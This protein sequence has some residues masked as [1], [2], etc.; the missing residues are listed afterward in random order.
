M[1]GLKNL[2]HEEYRAK[3]KEYIL[4]QQIGMGLLAVLMLLFSFFY[5]K[6][7]KASYVYY[8]EN[9]NAIHYAHL[10]PKGQEIFGTDKLNGTHA[11]VSSLVEKMSAK[12]TYEINFVTEK[13]KYKYNYD[14]QTQ[15]EVTDV[16]SRSPLY[17][18]IVATQVEKKSVE[19]EGSF[20]KIAEDVDINFKAFNK[21]A[22]DFVIQNGLVETTSTLIVRMSVT[23]WGASEN[24]IT[25]HTDEYVT[26]LRVPLRNLAFKP[27]VT[28]SV[29]AGEKKI[30]AVS[31]NKG[32]PFLVLAIVSASVLVWLG[33]WFLYFVLSTKDEFVDYSIK[34][35]RIYKN[36]QSYIQ[37]IEE[38]F[39]KA[40]RK[41]L[42]L[43][44]FNELLEIH[45]L[46]Q[47]P[48]L[49]YEN[50]EKT[51]TE[52]VLLSDSVL[53]MHEIKVQEPD[54][55]TDGETAQFAVDEKPVETTDE[56][57]KKTLKK[58]TA[59][60]DESESIA[61]QTSE[62]VN[63]VEKTEPAANETASIEIKENAESAIEQT[64][65]A[66]ESEKVENTPVETEKNESVSEVE[67]NEIA[68]TENGAN[69]E[70]Q[71]ANDAEDATA[72]TDNKKEDDANAASQT[73]DEK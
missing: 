67:Q 34:V 28:S 13:V 35:A 25:D 56:T 9:G 54:D 12:F 36:Y 26:E 40:R 8:S 21:Q 17:N 22:D 48:I 7:D 60:K 11:Y 72:P 32:I 70:S 44:E 63:E 15:L 23:V 43:K 30:L 66:S 69:G 18:P 51:R 24:F 64:E 31:E 37:V 73:N 2:S 57:K 52:F 16:S 27:V 1:A 71:S 39:P 46:V 47:K 4:Y 53:Y 41:V 20:F 33:I 14:I 59:K 45:D 49:M 58:R 65:T 42:R 55:A 19:G 3:R 50:P 62:V 6:T 61:S 10:T 5:F 29:P 68:P 38:E